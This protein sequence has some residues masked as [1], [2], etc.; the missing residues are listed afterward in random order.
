MDRQRTTAP[1]EGDNNS[2]A[3]AWEDADLRVE[4]QHEGPDRIREEAG[5]FWHWRRQG[6]PDHQ[7]GVL[8]G[9]LRGRGAAVA[10]GPQGVGVGPERDHCGAAKPRL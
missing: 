8:D 5:W 6:E 4:Q 10:Q 2:S 3:D 9:H 1:C 7:L